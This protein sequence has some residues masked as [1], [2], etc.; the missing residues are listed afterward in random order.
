MKKN[1][2]KNLEKK[3]YKI[4]LTTPL[5]ILSIAVLALCL[6]G[7]GL[8]VWRI[9]RFGVHNLTDVIKYPFLIAVCLF[10]IALEISI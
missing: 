1:L 5:L 2:D 4:Q 8:S 7:I 9:S 6:V 3:I 10:C